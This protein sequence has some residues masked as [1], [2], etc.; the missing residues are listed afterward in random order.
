MI[1]DES[2]V[3]ILKSDRY[4]REIK[5]RAA[6]ICGRIG[7]GIATAL[8]VSQ[9]G[10]SDRGARRAILTA[11]HHCG[12]VA[13]GVEVVDVR[14][15]LRQ[16]VS[17]LAWSL[18]MA[19]DLEG[20]SACELLASALTYERTLTRHRCVLSL[21]FIYDAK[22]VLR[23]EENLAHSSS[24]QRAYAL[25]ALSAEMEEVE[26]DAGKTVY[27]KGGSG[28]TMYI[29]VSGKVKVHEGDRTFV[30]L[31]ERD[32]F[33]ERTTLDPAP[34]SASVTAVEQTILLGLDREASMN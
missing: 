6:S 21:S 7:A 17:D 23:V 9:M 29:V 22:T 26:V 33:G 14:L 4:P 10:G 15:L 32:F 27:E 12:F 30:T 2:M 13:Q 19:I 34:H 8:L 3:D 18:S 11:L 25:E 24:L 28:R 16:E 1:Y 5:M 31:G 20:N